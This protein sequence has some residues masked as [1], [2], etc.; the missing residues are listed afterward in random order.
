MAKKV[1]LKRNVIINSETRLFLPEIAN[2]TACCCPTWEYHSCVA[3]G[4]LTR[5]AV[6]R[7]KFYCPSPD[8]YNKFEIIHYIDGE[9]QDGTGNFVTNYA[10]G[11]SKLQQFFNRNCFFD[12]QVHIGQCERA[13]LFNEFDKILIL[14]N[15]RLTDYSLTSIIARSAADVAPITETAAFSFQTMTEISKPVFTLYETNAVGDGPIIDS[16][17]FCDTSCCLCSEFPGYY[18]VQLIVCD[19]NTNCSKL[20]VVYT[21]DNGR[22]FN[23]ITLDVDDIN[24]ATGINHNVV[25]TAADFYTELMNSSS[26]NTITAAIKNALTNFSTT[27]GLSFF[28]AIRNGNTVYAV[29]ELGTLVI[30]DTIAQTTTVQRSSPFQNNRDLL[31]IDTADGEVFVIGGERGHVYYGELDSLIDQQLPVQTD[32][33]LVA[34]KSECSY[35][36]AT[37][38]TGG[39]V[40]CNN[41]YTKMKG[42]PGAITA[43]TFYDDYLGFAAAN[44][45]SAINIYQT[46]DGGFNWIAI[47]TQLDNT[48]F[49]STIS[50]CDDNPNRVTLAGSKDSGYTTPAQQIQQT[51]AWNQLGTGFVMIGNV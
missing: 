45:G 8:T 41:H 47:D 15:V 33:H 30:Y 31:S 12:L 29:G 17:A 28:N 51:L 23:V 9:Q 5:T 38:I 44:V 16:F 11:E 34:M 7:T 27:L 24:Q 6:E 18:Y 22:T 2:D 26:G 19:G 10:L 21:T 46:V 35:A 37:D 32:A 25:L 20:R 36:V 40:Y 42:I 3:I 50:V 13:D 49:V 14:K 43:M 48:Y 4:D 39:Y 1:R